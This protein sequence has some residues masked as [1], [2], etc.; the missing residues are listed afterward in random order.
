MK[1]SNG[2]PGAVPSTTS[3][4]TNNPA[5]FKELFYRHYP[6][7][8]R[9]L[10]C[11]LGSRADAEDIAQEAFIK[12]FNTPPRESSNL[13]GWLSRVATNLAYNH[14]RSQNSRRRR[15]MG[16]SVA[17]VAAEAGPETAA[18]REEEIAL[19]R[20]VL[21]LIPERDRACLLLK[22]SGMNYAA[23]ARVID[24]KESSVGTL[25]ARARA[26]FRSEY[27]KLTGSDHDVL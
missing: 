11:L 4:Y 17:P 27:L 6:A 2:G 14:L 10:T 3:E 12:L 15:E 25:L 20:K 23:I 22:F 24:V 8:C 1:P 18:L 16:V 26:R 7:V 5:G 21:E 13:G 19:T 9:Q